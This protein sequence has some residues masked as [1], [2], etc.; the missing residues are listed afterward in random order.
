MGFTSF[1]WCFA[2]VPHQRIEIVHVL[3]D[4]TSDALLKSCSFTLVLN[5]LCISVRL[6]DQHSQQH[7]VI[8][9]PSPF[10]AWTSS[11]GLIMISWFISYYIRCVCRDF[12]SDVH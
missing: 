10:A 2:G 7:T 9:R 4:I 8:V 11:Y 3:V 5:A 6:A 12:P 1:K